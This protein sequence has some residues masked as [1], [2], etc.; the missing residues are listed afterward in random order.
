[1]AN[2]IVIESAES[3]GIKIRFLEFFRIGFVVT[4]VTMFLSFGIIS[5]QM[6]IR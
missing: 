4:L 3:K 2:L 1:M 6:Q 5:L